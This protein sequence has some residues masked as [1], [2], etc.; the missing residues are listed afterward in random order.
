MRIIA[1][2]EIKGAGFGRM[3]SYPIMLY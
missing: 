1:S 2:G 3:F